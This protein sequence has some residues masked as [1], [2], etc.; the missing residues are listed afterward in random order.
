MSLGIELTTA[1]LVTLVKEEAE[2][3]RTS[4]SNIMKNVKGGIV[5][6]LG[7]LVG[8][9]YFER[10][11][12][13]GTNR[14]LPRS[15]PWGFDSPAPHHLTRQVKIALRAGRANARLC[16][17]RYLH[18]NFNPKLKNYSQE[19]NSLLS[20][21]GLQLVGYGSARVAAASSDSIK[22]ETVRTG[23]QACLV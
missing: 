9:F 20:Q 18:R 5:A 3:K 7:Y 6:L 12:G 11:T 22:S 8:R 17:R 23:L 19:S 13:L 2:M 10:D 14:S 15:A 21:S 1:P 16:L 4:N